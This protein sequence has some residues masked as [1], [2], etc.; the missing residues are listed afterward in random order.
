MAAACSSSKAA[1]SSIKRNPPPVEAVGARLAL[2]DTAPVEPLGE[3]AGSVG[4]GSAAAAVTG[5]DIA[6]VE[7][8]AKEEEAIDTGRIGEERSTGGRMGTWRWEGER[9]KSE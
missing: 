2:L 4:G 5:V 8:A 9:R 1:S 3:T 6:V 7:A